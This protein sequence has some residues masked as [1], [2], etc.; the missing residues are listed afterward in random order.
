MGP[1]TNK[2]YIPS[3]FIL[4]IGFLLSC[5]MFYE[6][7][8][9]E[10]KFAQYKFKEERENYLT[11][12]NSELI[13][14]ITILNTVKQLFLSSKS[15]DRE[16]FKTFTNFFLEDNKKVQALLWVPLVK[17]DERN[18]YERL[19]RKEGYKNFKFTEIGNSGEIQKR[20]KSFQYYPVYYI[21]PLR[22]N[23]GILGL[24][25][26]SNKNR[27][28]AILNSL[29]IGEII[30][31]SKI[32]LV[33]GKEEKNVFFIL[34]PIYKKGFSSKGDILGFIAG[35]FKIDDLINSSLDL[36]IKNNLDF[37]IY[38]AAE[39]KNTEIYTTKD[40]SKK[41]K[42]YQFSDL[43][44]ED[45]IDFTNRNWK[46]RFIPGKSFFL[47]KFIKWDWT[48]FV[49][50]NI[51]T[52]IWSRRVY[53]KIK[54][55]NK[56]GD[57]MEKSAESEKK[58]KLFAQIL[59]NTPEGVIV[60]NRYNKI[61][62]VNNSFLKNTGYLKKDV[63]GYDPK[64][65]NSNHHKPFFYKEMWKSIKSKGGWQGEIWDRKKNGEISPEWLNI[66]TI[67][68][69]KKKIDYHIG[70]FSDL[71][72]QKH[73]R[74]QIQHLAHY[75]S[76]TDLSNRELFNSRAKSLIINADADKTRMAFLFLD[77]DR[78][79]NINDTLGHSSG[80]ELLIKVAK[81]LKKITLKNEIIARF[82][83]DEFVILKPSFDFI[84]DL[85]TLITNILNVFESPFNIDGKDLFVTTS[86]GISLYPL[87]GESL[88][89]LIKNADTA[90]Y[91]AK[92][93]GR[94][95]YKFYTENMNSKF[96]KNLD[97]ENKMREALKNEEFYLEY[98][99]QVNTV[100]KKIVS[101]EALIRWKNP[102]F[103]IV[104]PN[105]FIGIAEE[106]GLIVPM[107]RWILEKVF[108]EV[109]KI[110]EIDPNI[111]LSINISG[112]QIKHSNL[113]KM[114][115]DV[116][117]KEKIDLKH[118]EL[119]LTESTLMD[120]VSKNIET[121]LK[122]K[123]LKIKLAIDDFGTG[124]SSLSYLKKF[125]IDRLKIDK[126]FIDGI[127][128]NEEDKIIVKTIISMAHNLGFKVVAEGVETK[129]QFDF[130]KSYKCDQIQGY[131]FSKPVS[132]EK[133]QEYLEKNTFN[134]LK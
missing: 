86:I 65:L 99:P 68:N 37:Q 51:I 12:L 44:F 131:Y 102:Q 62:S 53:K 10:N 60:T 88:N 70:I 7:R 126:N 8:I 87:D 100:T 1:N 92:K 108:S 104:S 128:T 48:I 75:D 63:I 115:E 29:K 91:F 24:D 66:I 55:T 117:D 38:D 96:M 31:T 26:Y 116:L 42:L 56:I 73:I 74:N 94:N 125:P 72:N 57:L 122:L 61:I 25:L 84:D 77:L 93:S 90:M 78:F 130:L 85:N 118:I 17:S 58:L 2:S 113:P 11:I 46:I 27:A 9:L 67:R 98:Q 106:S 47:N 110:I 101:C 103:G 6:V 43:Y 34:N 76:L 3:Y 105:E 89:E 41:L 64:I 109:K 50:L 121:M 133:I 20:E 119:E 19:A 83:G 123:D 52:V 15:V 35:I 5:L 124:Y 79:K 111:Y 14:K 33:Q 49:F 71:S 36:L 16:G 54:Y 95:T 39:D 22:G 32:K 4:F 134:L 40:Y 21:E 80:D 23:E 28:E 18:R 69:N 59:E 45:S 97:L 120:D 13:K 127:V 112:Y 132:I 82:G 30:G 114:I 107:T 129:K 81:S